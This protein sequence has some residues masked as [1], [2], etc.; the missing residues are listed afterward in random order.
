MP[1]VTL[2]SPAVL[3]HQLDQWSEHHLSR[4][5]KRLEL[6]KALPAR[7]THHEKV[8]EIKTIGLPEVHV[9]GQKL[10]FPYLKVQELLLYLIFQP[11]SPKDQLQENLWPGGLAHNVYTAVRQLKLL[12]GQ[13]LNMDDPIVKRRCGYALSD[14]IKV[15]LDLETISGPLMPGGKLHPAFTLGVLEGFDSEWLEEP[16]ALL[17]QNLLQRLLTEQTK[18]VGKDKQLA[19]TLLMLRQ[20]PFHAEALHQAS[21]LAGQL[22][23]Q[24]V[25]DLLNMLE[26]ALQQGTPLQALLGKLCDVASTL[27]SDPQGRSA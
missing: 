12:L 16:R 4:I 1:E 20:D 27:M 5:R 24:R 26:R 8:L 22:G 11:F 18:Q 9:N 19:L 25:K 21:A 17:Q 23:D 3:S 6:E 13:H 10:D 15:V 14:Q 7:N 2:P